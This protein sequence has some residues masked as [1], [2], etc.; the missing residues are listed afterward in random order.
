LAR[1]RPYSAP[2]IPSCLFHSSTAWCFSCSSSW[3]TSTSAWHFRAGCSPVCSHDRIVPLRC[4]CS[5]GRLLCLSTCRIS[6]FAASGSC[7]SPRWTVKA[8][9]TT[10]LEIGYS[11]GF[12]GK[13]ILLELECYLMLGYWDD[14]DC[15]ICVVLCSKFQAT[16][17][18]SR[19]NFNTFSRGELQLRENFT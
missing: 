17:N 6:V 10:L 2:T 11:Y 16:S 4:D 8:C 7:H 5:T 18:F 14:D 15:S 19:E 12:A 1:T 13:D 9:S 3:I